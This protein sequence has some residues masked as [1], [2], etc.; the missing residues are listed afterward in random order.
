MVSKLNVIYLDNAATSWPKPSPVHEAVL[1]AIRDHG[2]NPGR[3]GHRMS[4]SAGRLIQETRELIA[5]LFNI[6][7]PKRV[8]FTLNTTEALN[9]ALKGYLKP[10]EHVITTSLE[11]N[12]I[13]R[14]LEVLRKSGVQVTRIPVSLE[15]GIAVKDIIEAIRDNTK[16]IA[17]TH[18]SNVT[19][20]VNPLEAIG[21]VA[22]DYKIQLLV[23][24]AQTAGVFPIDV[25]KMRIDMLAFAGHKS[26]LGP[27]GVGGLY[28]NEGIELRPLKEGGTGSQSESVIQP[29]VMPD[30]Y[31]SGT[32]NTPGIAGLAAGIK[33]IIS[34]G[35]PKI[36]SY[37][38]KLVKHLQE[39]LI[40]IPGVSIYGPQAVTNK[41][42]VVSFN[43]KGLDPLEVAAI[44][45]Q[46]FNIA[47]RS[48][49]HCAPEVCRALGALRGGT[50]RFSLGYFNT[51][52]DLDLCIEAV[53][54]IVC[55]N[56]NSVDIGG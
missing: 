11:H 56:K 38:E 17:I 45:D 4:V 36:H 48:G 53:S 55:E 16:L 41:A 30:R 28:I 37:E 33:Y 46:S 18:A 24:A 15:D 19:G 51:E 13:L 23:D 31:E 35:I 42:P 12:S 14:P 21:K 10:G 8:I 20:T 9:L 52:Q 40:K 26:L 49:L 1:T 43:I 3:S 5:G 50:L 39:G 34:E 6:A 32:P 27:Q 2:G 25:R 29:N 22:A 7:D 44:L 47:C 54:Q